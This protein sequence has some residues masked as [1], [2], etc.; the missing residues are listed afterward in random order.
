[1]KTTLEK[2]NW[3]TVSLLCDMNDR[4]TAFYNVM[5]ANLKNAMH[6]SKTRFEVYDVR[7]N[8]ADGKELPVASMLEMFTTRLRGTANVYE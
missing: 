3:T 5:C 6:N 8:T 2:F 1:M 4:M 7:F